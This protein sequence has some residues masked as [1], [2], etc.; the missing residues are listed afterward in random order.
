MQIE[1]RR[2]KREIRQAKHQR[3][4]KV[5]EEAEL[6][7]QRGDTRS[8]YQYVRLSVSASV[9]SWKS[10]VHDVSIKLERIAIQALTGPDPSV[11]EDWLQVQLAWLPKP[12]KPPTEA[13][14]LRTIGLM[15]PDCKAFLMILKKFANPFVQE[16]MN[17]YP[18]YAYR[19]GASTSDP[20]LR[21][22]LHCSQVRQDLAKCA[23]DL[24]SKILYKA[25]PELCGGIMAN[26]D[27]RKAFDSLPFSE[28]ETGMPSEL[29]SVIMDVHVRTTLHI[30]HGGD[31]GSATMTR[32]LRQGCPI[33]PMVYAAWTCRICRLLNQALGKHWASEHLSMYAD[34]KHA[35]WRVCS[36]SSFRRALSQLRVVIQT[37]REAKMEVNVGKS[38]VVI[39]LKGTQAQRVLHVHTRTWNGI[40]SLVLRQ[41]GQCTS[42]YI[43][44]AEQLPYLGVVLSY[45]QFEL[46]T[47]QARC[48]RADKLFGSLRRVLRT[49]GLLSTAQ[50]LRIYKAC[51]VP[52]LHYG[53]MAVGVNQ[54]VLKLL[55]STH[56]QHLRKLLRVYEHGVTNSEVMQRAQLDLYSELEAKAN[57]QVLAICND[58]GRDVHLRRLEEA[59][60]QCNQKDLRQLG[61]LPISMCLPR[62]E[63]TLQQVINAWYRE[64]EYNALTYTDGVVVIQLGRFVNGRKNM[65]PISVEEAYG[66]HFS[67]RASTMMDGGLSQSVSVPYTSVMDTWYGSSSPVRSSLTLSVMGD[68]M[69]EAEQFFFDL[70]MPHGKPSDADLATEVPSSEI[71]RES[72]A[73]GA[74]LARM[75]AN[76]NPGDKGGQGKGRNGYG[77]RKR[78]AQ[79]WTYRGGQQG[80]YG[81]WDR[82]H[83]QGHDKSEA[84]IQQALH[85]L[86]KL[87][88]RHED[89]SSFFGYMLT[90]LLSNP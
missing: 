3:I 26:L 56:A 55:I 78:G 68:A 74:K 29:A 79:P 81:H 30:R 71:S 72:E 14:H 83:W 76:G 45:R 17:I 44:L 51:V 84:D 19:Q 24:T 13:S 65:T 86:Q 32:G 16:R 62:A 41:D 75:A 6:A 22:S 27:L 66:F 34:D 54:A 90:A 42:I 36:V 39:A 85:T 11:P 73:R 33:A 58:A 9:D 37:L 59:R 52:A 43:P 7:A 21:A 15:T 8:L 18:Q 69:Q 10:H 53:I 49:R 38:A 12:S 23:T 67:L 70:Y 2:L 64:G 35:F 60:A 4:L 80:E 63:A 48:S 57:R 25:Q 88:L 47:A 77:D 61:G 40:D 46:H 1:H 28:L 5:L 50:R 20:I 82:R 87:V 31:H 89:L